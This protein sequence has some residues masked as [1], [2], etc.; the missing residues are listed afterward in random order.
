MVRGSL[1]PLQCLFGH[2]ILENYRETGIINNPAGDEYKHPPK[3]AGCPSAV[4]AITVLPYSEMDV[5]GHTDKWNGCQEMARIG[6]T[7]SHWKIL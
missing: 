1:N 7:G 4:P 6:I 2:V 3:A 5:A